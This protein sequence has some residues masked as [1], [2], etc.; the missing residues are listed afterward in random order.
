LASDSEWRIYCAEVQ[1]KFDN[2]GIVAVAI[3][4]DQGSTAEIDSFLMS[5]R[6]IGRGIEIALMSAILNGCSQRG[7][8]KVYGDYVKT[9]KN[10]LAGPFLGDCGFVQDQES[11]DGRW[12]F[13]P[14]RN[15]VS[16]PEWFRTIATDEREPA[17]SDIA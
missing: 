1:D 2:A 16:M 6:V 13:E 12:S 10:Q 11:P 17:R 15:V 7:I 8:S 9:A 5:C 3:V 14:D 4:R